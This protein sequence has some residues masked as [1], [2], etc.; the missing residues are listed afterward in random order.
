M[1][2]RVIFLVLLLAAGG[3]LAGTPLAGVWQLDAKASDQ[4]K[5]LHKQIGTFDRKRRHDDDNG[6]S[7]DADGAGPPPFLNGVSLKGL[8]ALDSSRVS[9]RASNREVVFDFGHGHRRTVNPTLKTTTVSLSQ[10]GHER[11]PA[12]QFSTWEDGQLVVETTRDN[13]F[14]IVEHWSV[15]ANGHL[16]V[17]FTLHPPGLAEPIRYHREFVRAGSTKTS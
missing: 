11:D 16:Q 15:D 13:G 3:A 2:K 5:E 14:R 4:F 10:Y 1:A 6:D 17:R 7:Q 12:V 8:D 9:I